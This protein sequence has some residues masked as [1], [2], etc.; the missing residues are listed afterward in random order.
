MARDTIE[1][2]FLGQ[3]WA[4]P[5]STDGAGDVKDAAGERDVEEAIRIV[6]GT[7]KGERVM[8]PDFG[9]GIHDHVFDTIDT[10]TRTLIETS[11]EEALIE[12][13]PR[14]EVENIETSTERLASGMLE[15]SVDY[16]VLD[17]NNEYNLVYPLYVGGE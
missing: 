8:R 12:H 5:V 16:R 10:A 3:G 4:F 9:C 14:I 1:R 7:A 17:A 15:I 11:V 2:K 13:E 6:I